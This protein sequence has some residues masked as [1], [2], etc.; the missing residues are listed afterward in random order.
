MEEDH[1]VHPVEELG[2]EVLPER[3]CHLP[4]D[5]LGQIA[6]VLGDEV[7]AEVRRHDDHDVLEVDRSTL[8][9]RQASVVE[10]LQQHVEH[11][12]VR[13]LDFVEEDDGVRP[14]RTASVSCPASS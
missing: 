8:A 2:T 1:F 12:G 9:V 6:R 14:P 10:E 13:L 4:A 7:A 3:L 11:L 5:A